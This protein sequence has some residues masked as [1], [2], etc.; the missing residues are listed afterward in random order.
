MTN[1]L[2]CID[3]L[4]KAW[5]PCYPMYCYHSLLLI[6]EDI[7]FNLVTQIKC[8]LSTLCI[9]QENLCHLYWIGIWTNS[10]QVVYTLEQLIFQHMNIPFFR[11]PLYDV[12]HRH[13]WMNYW[14]IRLAGLAGIV[15]IHG[16]PNSS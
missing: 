3:F 5:Q 14:G 8:V 4:S 1:L 11:L 15:G 2:R 9:T 7:P 12:T 10:E 16:S 13:L 6:M